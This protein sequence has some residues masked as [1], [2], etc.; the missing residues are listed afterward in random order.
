MHYTVIRGGETL[1]IDVPLVRRDP[2]AL[3]RYFVQ[4]WQQNPRDNL[5]AFLSLLIAAFAFFARP[6]NHPAQLLLLIWSYFGAA[7]WFGFAD[8]HPY[9]SY[10]PAPLALLNGMLTLTW[11]WYFFPTW[12]LLALSFPV[13]KAPYR[14]FPRLVPIVLYAVPAV[15]FVAAE[16]LVF[17]SRSMAWFNILQGVF[18]GIVLL[19][20]VTL[21]ASLIHNWL[22]L[23]SPILRAQLVWITLGLGVGW[24]ATIWAVFVWLL[25]FGTSQVPAAVTGITGWLGLLLPLSLAIAITRYRLF[26]IEVII[27]RTL[28]YGM[29]TALLLVFYF[30]S[31]ILLQQ[32]FRALSGQGQ[33]LAII[34]S[35]LAIA[36]LVVPLRN[37]VQKEI[38]RRFYRRKYDAAQVLARFAATARDEVDLSRLTDNLAGVVEETMRP[39]SV[40]VWLKGTGGGRRR[41]EE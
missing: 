6:R 4:A 41:M 30:G 35:T 29:L 20:G 15:F 17:T 3:A 39:E 9:V 1:S 33:D 24:G 5:V 10:Y 31:V 22:T 2:A 34:L 40:S 7:Q 26:D 19:F 32:A 14:R 21:A 13:L 23:R 28:V 27:R 16:T 36:A 37:R 25:F 18:V 12:I 11:A 38:D 8:W